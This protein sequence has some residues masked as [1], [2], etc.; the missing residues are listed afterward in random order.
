MLNMRGLKGIMK[1]SPKH[2]D[3]SICDLRVKGSK[4]Q[5]LVELN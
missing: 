2:L 4:N 5:V 3:Y 1:A